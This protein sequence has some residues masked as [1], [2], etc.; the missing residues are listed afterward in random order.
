MSAFLLALA[1]QEAVTPTLEKDAAFS[2]K[3][4]GRADLACDSQWHS[5]LRVALTAS[6]P[7]KLTEPQLKPLMPGRAVKPGD[8][9]KAEGESLAPLMKELCRIEWV[10]DDGLEEAYKKWRGDGRNDARIDVSGTLAMTLAP[11]GAGSMVVAEG[12]LTVVD[13][14]RMTNRYGPNNWSHTWTH[15]LR[16]ELGLDAAGRV[17]A[18]VVRD[19]FE[20]AG[21]Y[22]NDAAA[23]DPFTIKGAL[24][25]SAPKKATADEEKAIRGHVGK[26]GSDDLDVR[27]AAT[28]ALIDLG[29]VVV[30]TVKAARGESDDPEVKARLDSVLSALGEE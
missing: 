26:L 21:E 4:K 6:G 13:G 11:A 18:V 23:R 28:K 16:I 7:L 22:N 5:G 20:V 25:T 10:P 19:V 3:V 12:T 15:K 24:N 8:A 9:W 29:D 27:E 2:R 17:T 1:W 30:D 14:G